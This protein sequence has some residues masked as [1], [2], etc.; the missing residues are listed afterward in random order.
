MRVAVVVELVCLL[1]QVAGGAGGY[2]CVLAQRARAE[3]EEEGKLR[4]AWW[5]R[6]QERKACGGA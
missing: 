4:L 1:L 3:E 2:V 6:P 5:S